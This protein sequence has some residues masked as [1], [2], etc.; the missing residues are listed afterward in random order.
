MFKIKIIFIN[1]LFTLVFVQTNINVFCTNFFSFSLNLILFFSFLK[2]II[3][4]FIVIKL[5]IINIISIFFCNEFYETF[6]LG[7]LNILG[8]FH[9]L[10]LFLYFFFIVLQI[11]INFDY[12]K[13]FFKKRNKYF[14]LKYL[15]I[16]FFLGSYWAGQELLWGGFWNWDLVEL[17]LFLLVFNS[18]LGFHFFFIK[19]TF[20]KTNYYFFKNF[21]FVIWLYF[22]INRSPLI[23]SQHL[24]SASFF[25]SIDRL[26]YLIVYSFLVFCIVIYL[27]KQKKNKLFLFFWLMILC[28]YIMFFIFVYWNYFFSNSLFLNKIFFKLILLFVIVYF[29]LHSNN[30]LL[31]FIFSGFSFIIIYSVGL[32]YWPSFKKFVTKTSHFAYQL[33]L[34]FFFFFFVSSTG[35]FEIQNNIFFFLKKSIVTTVGFGYEFT[36]FNTN[37][38]NYKPIHQNILFNLC[39][40]SD[41]C[42]FN[43]K[44]YEVDVQNSFLSNCYIYTFGFI[45]ILYAIVCSKLV[46][47]LKTKL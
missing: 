8:F 20:Y 13:Y 31:Y 5:Y 15:V 4:F 36:N 25:F 27:V 10:L 26:F 33:I 37:I 45:H 40:F 9:P 11:Q 46:S 43:N 35:I 12:N 30:S 2:K 22:I 14:N 39:F 29:L 24:F 28:F 38:L 6:N 34:I 23:I 41:L 44:L 32:K 16:T 1:L 17:T 21:L 3:F 42:Y 18:I 19:Y 47:F 7:L